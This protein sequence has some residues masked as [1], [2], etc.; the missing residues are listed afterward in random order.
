MSASGDIATTEI[1]NDGAPGEFRQQRRVVDLNCESLLRAM[2]DRLTVAANR[3]DLRGINA[4]RLQRL[5]HGVG[6]ASGEP[7]AAFHGPFQ[8]VVR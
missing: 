1:S 4:S 2:P 7:E 3:A 5:M 6:I 8:L